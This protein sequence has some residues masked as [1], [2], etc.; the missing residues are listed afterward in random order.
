MKRPHAL[1]PHLAATQRLLALAL[2]LALGTPVA[3]L[4][5]GQDIEKINGAITAESGKQ[6]GTLETVNG[7]ITVEANSRARTIET[8]NGSIRVAEGVQ[9]SSLSTVNGSIRA[10]VGTQLADGA[11]T[12]NGSVFIDRGSR[13]GKGVATV[14]GAIGLV[15]TDVGGNVETVNGDV[16]IG[17]DSHVRGQVR[18]EKPTS[19]WMPIT[20]SKRTPRIVIG[21]NAV[22]DGPLVFEREV[23]LYVH[24]SAR[25]GKV[26]GATPISYS[27]ARAPQ[28]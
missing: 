21:P 8:V 18:V 13:L 1:L 24:Q 23:V 22:V 7:S 15:G 28:E 3:A 4:A 5:A 11:E 14:N 26:T 20:L 6:Y 2:A 19:N 17:I 10:G 16:T 27:G 12:V 25:I 9:A